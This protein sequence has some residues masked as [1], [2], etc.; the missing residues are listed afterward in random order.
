MHSSLQLKRRGSET[1]SHDD[2]L[3]RRHKLEGN[4]ATSY[5]SIAI[6]FSVPLYHII[7][8]TKPLEPRQ[9]IMSGEI[10]TIARALRAAGHNTLPNG[11]LTFLQVRG[12]RLIESV[13]DGDELKDQR[14]VAS[15][16]RE[17]ST[18]DYAVAKDR[19][20][21]SNYMRAALL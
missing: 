2:G 6:E 20:S 12:R 4:A 7:H 1:T 18:A 17:G 10:R 11:D 5:Y 16:L 15:G 13:Y 8:I 19:V 9:F 21:T 3:F 14:M